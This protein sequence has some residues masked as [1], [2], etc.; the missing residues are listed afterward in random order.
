MNNKFYGVPQ[1]LG[2]MNLQEVN[3]KLFSSIIQEST[4]DIVKSII[5][6]EDN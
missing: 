2:P 5:D 4:M 1:K 3:L 6:K